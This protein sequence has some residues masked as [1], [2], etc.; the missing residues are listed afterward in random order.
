MQWVELRTLITIFMMLL[1][2]G[3]AIL[4]TTNLWRHFEAIERWILAIGL[5]I[6]FYPVLYYLIRELLPSVRL[7]QNKFIVILV[8]F[9]VL[10]DI[11]ALCELGIDYV[12]DGVKNSFDGSQFNIPAIQ[13]A[14]N[15]QIIYQDSG[16]SIY[17][18]C[19]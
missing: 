12:Y 3:W 15:T 16:V 11:E 10:V 5:S 1:V 6:A 13:Q 9:F 14:E 18:I 4:A 8:A 17:K 2:P 19:E 7:G